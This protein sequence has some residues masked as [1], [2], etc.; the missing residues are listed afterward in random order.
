MKNKITIKVDIPEQEFMEMCLNQ[1]HQ[2]NQ[3][4]TLA[5]GFYA[6]A[7]KWHLNKLLFLMRECNIMEG[8]RK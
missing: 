7:N 2:L 8:K 3:D 6:L 5:I 1:S 4:M